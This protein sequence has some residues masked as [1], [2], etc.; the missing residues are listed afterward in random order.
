MEFTKTVFRSGASLAII[1]PYEIVKA[2]KINND[3]MII[4]DIKK[5][6]RD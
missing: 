5:V 3:D 6:I 4:L 1:I 2:Y